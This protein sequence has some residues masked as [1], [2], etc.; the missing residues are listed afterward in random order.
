MSPYHLAR[1]DSNSASLSAAARGGGEGGGMIEHAAAPDGMQM[2]R[3]RA[4]K[5]AK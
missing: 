5:A 2:T 4:T 3:A 1:L